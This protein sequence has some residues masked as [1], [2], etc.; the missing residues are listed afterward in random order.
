MPDFHSACKPVAVPRRLEQ[1]LPRLRRRPRRRRR[2][3]Q[4]VVELIHQCRRVRRDDGRARRTQS[5][6]VD[7]PLPLRHRLRSSISAGTRGSRPIGE[8]ERG[9]RSH[10]VDERMT[11]HP[12]QQLPQSEPEAHELEQRQREHQLQRQQRGG[13]EAAVRRA[14]DRDQRRDD[15]VV[16]EHAD[17]DDR[18]DRHDE[19]A[20]RHGENR[21]IE[22]RPRGPQRLDVAVDRLLDQRLDRRSRQRDVGTAQPRQLRCAPQD[23]RRAEEQHRQRRAGAAARSTARAT[24]PIDSDDGATAWRHS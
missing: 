22:Q 5:R 11:R 4:L 9:T 17:R 23:Q 6:G 10:G 15:R 14:F 8:S 21:S 24:N 16:R 13:D 2:P 3:P 19:Q 12:D 7:Q 18:G 1:N 20:G